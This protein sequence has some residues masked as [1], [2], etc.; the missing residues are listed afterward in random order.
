MAPRTPPPQL[1]SEFDDFL[2]AAIGDTAAGTSLSVASHLARLD[3]DPWQEAAS[4]ASMPA[5]AAGER[6]AEL[7]DQLTDPA[8]KPCN[9][10]VTALRL[11]ILLPRHAAGA[12]KR[13]LLPA[14]IAAAASPTHQNRIVASFAVTV[15]LALAFQIAVARRNSPIRLA[16]AQPP[17]AAAT[18]CGRDLPA[19][20]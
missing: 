1:G 5:A 20:P 6:L 16:A 19:G 2:F 18:H 13:P 14:D 7:L 3:L 4:L 17:T 15:I 12:A 8:V 11:I 9:S 10:Q